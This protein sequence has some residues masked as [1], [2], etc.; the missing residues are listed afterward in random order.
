MLRQC[1]INFD[2]VCAFCL[3]NTDNLVAF[4]QMLYNLAI[5]NVSEDVLLASIMDYLIMMH[6]D[7]TPMDLSMNKSQPNEAG[8]DTPDPETDQDM[9][10][11]AAMFHQIQGQVR[12]PQPPTQGKIVL[13]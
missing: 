11:G 10:D 12:A 3:S 1:L 9:A 7:E 2:R 4:Q 6:A 13:H 5:Q 8:G